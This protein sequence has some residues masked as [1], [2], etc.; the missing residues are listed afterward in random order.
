MRHGDIKL[1]SGSSNPEL[2]EAVARRLGRSLG[3]IKVERF[4]DGEIH[5]EIGESVRGQDVY[6]IQSLSSPVN[7]HLMELLITIDALKRASAGQIT[8]VVPYYGY[9]RQDRQTTPRSPIT[10]RLVADL[11]TAAGT[12]RVMG[13]DLHAGQITGF[14][15]IPF[16]HLYSRPVFGQE[17]ERLAQRSAHPVVIVAPDAGGIKRARYYSQRVGASLAIIDKRRPKPNQAE[18]MNIIGDVEGATAVIVDDIIDTAGTLTQAAAAVLEHG[19]REVYACATHA[20]LSGPALKR[21]L[22]SP[23]ASVWVTDTIAPTEAIQGCDRIQRLSVAHI[24]GDAI[25]RVHGHRSVS[26]LFREH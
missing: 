13:I 19:A 8:A 10:A 18:V 16:D 21:I 24:L 9:A 15:N 4:S 25:E 2:A 5:V 12:T 3:R 23:L 22:A 20:V 7:D 6:V 1:F 14:F 26:S 11:L 17:L